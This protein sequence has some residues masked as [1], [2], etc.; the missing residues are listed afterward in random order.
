MTAPPRPVPRPIIVWFRHDLRLAD[1]PALAAAAE[2][3]SPVIP[4]RIREEDPDDRWL[5]GA[6]SRWWLH[7]SLER[8]G[9]ALA[10]LGSPLVLR[11]GRPE[12]VLADLAA[13]TGAAAVH[14]NRRYGPAAVAR[15]RRVEEALAARGIDVQAHN[16]ALLLEPEGI[17]TKGGTPFKVF[18]PFWRALLTLPEPPH[19]TRAPDRLT[20]PPKPVR[21]ERLADW[22]LR[23]TK[24]D[25]A[26]GLRETWEPGEDAARDRLADLLD[27]AI[28]EYPT[29]RDRPDTD[30]TSRLSPHLAFGEI[31][32]RQVWHASR[33]VADAHPERAAGIDAFLR[34]LGWREFNHHL[35][36]HFPVLP[37]DPLDQR[38]ARFP[39]QTGEATLTAWQRGRTG[40]PIVDAGLRQL[41]QTGWMHNRV[42]MIVG[43]FL[44][45]DLL[46]PW[47]TGQDWF[48]DTLVD[49]DLANNAANWQWVAG[50]GADAAPFF[51]VF[52]PVLQGE[53]FDPQGDYV[54]RFVPELARLPAKWIHKP[55]QAPAS[56]L[57]DAGV[58]L[59]RDY[60]DPVVEHDAARDRAL[61]AFATVRRK[62][63]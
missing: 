52:N 36:H 61:A 43:S 31:G 30:G 48:W 9:G 40:Y 27:G 44:I 18:T 25:W 20:A 19:P 11:S 37:E 42:R 23:P 24:P 34:E 14:W 56:V 63:A 53:K 39:W 15:D 13:E 49:A 46:L 60:P 7:G 16:A 51:R 28:T 1:N 57:A 21:S 5:P 32:P 55:W 35:L 29:L 62:D 17:R 12:A 2:S 38:F 41:W 59:G 47:Q 6:A 45:K 8:L 22:G 50:C 54:R 10:K 26:G 4:V 3:G 33:H 58:R